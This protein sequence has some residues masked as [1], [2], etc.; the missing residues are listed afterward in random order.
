MTSERAS[1]LVVGGGHNGLVAATLLARGGLAVTLLE[2]E[3]RVGGTL[4]TD[5]FHPGF[6]APAAFAGLERFHP[7]VAAELELERQG[8]RWLEPRGGTVQLLGGGESLRLDPAGDL[9]ATVARR[10]ATDGAALRSLEET[11]RRMTEAVAPLLIA[12]L[13]RA[14]ATLRER[15]SDLR[16][17]GG[18]WRAL[19]GAGLE[20]ALRLLPMNVR[21]VLDERLQDEVLKAAIAAP[22]LQSTFMGPRSAGSFWN[23]LWHRPAWVSHLLAPPR[24][25]V[26][27]PGAFA[28]SLEAS[29]RAAGVVIRTGTAVE[30]L[31]AAHGAVRGAV[32]PGGEEV[33]ASHVVSALDP[34]RTLLDLLDPGLLDIEVADEIAALRGRGNVAVVRIALDRLPRLGGVEGAALAGRFQT[35]TTLDDLERA[36]DASKYGRLAERPALEITVPSIADPS[37]APAG[38][39]VLHAWV[40]FVPH[41]PRR[42]DGAEWSE[43]DLR[44]AIEERV[45]ATLDEHD[46]GLSASVLAASVLTPA[47]FA[48]RFGITDGC[49]YHLEPALDQAL[50]LRPALGWHLHSTPIDRLWLAGP[51]TH[52]GGGPTGLP[53]RCA[54]RRLLAHSQAKAPARLRRTASG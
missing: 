20:E 42:D 45:I 44:A 14:K 10:S 32:L 12:P 7:M 48:A 54:A 52:P 41:R 1:V 18:A 23:L 25:A 53:G 8:L 36:Y 33:A 11:R 47:A 28:A 34:K 26:G 16:L 22:A 5:E 50:W 17:F 39:A 51:G 27:G 43:P 38:K 9:D 46:P 30:R 35:G 2:K 13:A 19:Y 29:A 15:V 4:A 24:Q 49:L 21:D 40:Q 6:R 37:L 3:Q 31:V